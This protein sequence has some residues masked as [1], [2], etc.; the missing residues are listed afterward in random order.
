MVNKPEEAKMV[1]FGSAA[2]LPEQR[3]TLCTEHPSEVEA[4]ILPPLCLPTA[5]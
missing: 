3:G 2:L 5:V 4:V 1:C